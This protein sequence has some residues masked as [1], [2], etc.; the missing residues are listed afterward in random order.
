VLT[1]DALYC[2]RCL[3][4]ALRQAGGDYLF[5]VKGNQPELLEDIRL[6]FA[7]PEPVKRAGEGIL[8]LPEQQ[9]Q[10]AETGHGRMDI[11]AYSGFFGTE[12]LF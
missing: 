12:R 2:Q 8:R 3:C 4:H 9:A 5:L 10:T 6:L 7:P 1:G 11:R